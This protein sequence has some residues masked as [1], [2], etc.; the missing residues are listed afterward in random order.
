MV[1]QHDR[2]LSDLESLVNARLGWQ[3][4]NSC[5]SSLLPP[6]ATPRS[7]LKVSG[8]FDAGRRCLAPSTPSPGAGAIEGV[9]EED[10]LPA[11]RPDRDAHH[12]D[13]GDLFDPSHVGPRGGGELVDA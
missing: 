8:T 7:R 4:E 5:N 9:L 3:P 13:S 1:T 11:I 12:R 2:Q 10:G 6:V